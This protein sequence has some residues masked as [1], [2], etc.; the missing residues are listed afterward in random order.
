METTS[1]DRERSAADRLAG[2]AGDDALFGGGGVDQLFGGP[3]VNLVIANWR[4]RKL[5]R[6]FQQTKI[7]QGKYYPARTLR[8]WWVCIA[9][10]I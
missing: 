5:R 2:H 6:G 3:G 4:R 1:T 8:G 9:I 10:A 7:K